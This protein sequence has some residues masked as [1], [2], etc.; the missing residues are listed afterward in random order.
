MVLVMFRHVFSILAAVTLVG[1]LQG[2]TRIA[3]VRVQD[4]YR[5]LP[6]T[7]A[8][9]T[10]LKER[11]DAITNDARTEQL[12]GLIDELQQLQIKLRDRAPDLDEATLRGLARDFEIKRQEA[13]TAQTEL[14]TYR[15]EQELLVNEVMVTA[16]RRSLTAIHE[17]AAKLAEEQGFTL[18]LDSSGNTNTGAPFLLYQ[19]QAVDLTE[20]VLASLQ[21]SPVERAVTEKAAGAKPT[22]PTSAAE[23][24][25]SETELVPVAPPTTDQ[26]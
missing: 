2:Q 1:S 22:E 11:R 17:T 5:E 12:R 6:S 20:T 14:E 23:A 4:I 18:V 19:K 13:Q 9:Q 8:L 25:Q 24:P 21:D 15:S 16:M 3:L 7:L 26:P 10:E